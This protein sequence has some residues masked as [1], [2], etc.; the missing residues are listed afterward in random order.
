[1]ALTLYYLF[2]SFSNPL[3]WSECDPE[4][5]PK[6]N[7]CVTANETVDF[8]DVRFAGDDDQTKYNNK[9]ASE[10]YWL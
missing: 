6:L 1:M 5:N 4:W 10:L 9:S 2:A 8:R 7:I 3:P